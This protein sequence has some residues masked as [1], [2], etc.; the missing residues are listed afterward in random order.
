[1]GARRWAFRDERLPPER[2]PTPPPH[3]QQLGPAQPA[4]GHDLRR[5][6][7][8][9]VTAKEE[10]GAGGGGAAEGHQ[11]V[12]GSDSP[13]GGIRLGRPL[14]GGDRWLVLSAEY[15]DSGRPAL[16]QRITY[17]PGQAAADLP[18]L[19]AW[20]SC[21]HPHVL[22]TLSLHRQRL[23]PRPHPYLR[24]GQQ[25]PSDLTALGGHAPQPIYRYARARFLCWRA[26]RLRCKAF[27]GPDRRG[28]LP[29]ERGAAAE[30]VWLV[31][32]WC[33]GGSLAARLGAPASG[34]L[35]QDDGTHPTRAALALAADVAGGLAYLHRSGLAHG[36]LS[37]DTVL[38][39]PAH[40]AA[41][42]AAATPA[43]EGA[44][45]LR[46][47]RSTSPHSSSTKHLRA[48]GGDDDGGDGGGGGGGGGIAISGDRESDGGGRSYDGGGGGGLSLAH[49][50]AVLCVPGRLPGMPGPPGLPDPAAAAPGGGLG[51]GRR[52]GGGGG[53][54]AGRSLV[55]CA[56]PE[57]LA[58]GEMAAAGEL[59]ASG[60][61]RLG[62]GCGF[63]HPS[64]DVYAFGILS[65]LL[66]TW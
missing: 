18:A 45:Q 9:W 35:G 48:D 17:G 56:A 13:P 59:P 2:P 44:R 51:G 60:G 39:Q 25:P 61:G 58:E 10:G 29:L 42:A 28:P 38:L 27:G 24:N 49:L 21:M 47:A 65:M 34:G 4:A 22:R 8:A 15:L 19:Q 11:V 55:A 12:L 62:G 53:G 33:E 16:V 46:M 30:V 36:A 31:Q 14:A 43:A 57:L 26:G 64:A 20:S 5:P 3:E 23:Q 37:A 6:L 7:A 32:G 50:T 63:V 40:L 41:A 1:M 66:V 52:G 54:G